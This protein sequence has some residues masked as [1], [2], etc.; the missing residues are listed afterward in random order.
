MRWRDFRES[1]VYL[2]HAHLSV[3]ECVAFRAEPR[4]ARPVT[5]YRRDLN[6]LAAAPEHLTHLWPR[7]SAELLGPFV[8]D[9]LRA[10]IIPRQKS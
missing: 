6:W 10:Q 9:Y 5:I 4:P 2:C 3:Q 7:V 8:E 1:P